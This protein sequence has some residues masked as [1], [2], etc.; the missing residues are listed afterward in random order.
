MGTSFSRV[1]LRWEGTTRPRPVSPRGTLLVLIGPDNVDP[2][3]C[4]REEGNF[5]RYRLFL[6]R[7]QSTLSSHRIVVGTGVG[8]GGSLSLVG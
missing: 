5:I 3:L 7:R 8:V 1:P 4:R 6:S 2:H